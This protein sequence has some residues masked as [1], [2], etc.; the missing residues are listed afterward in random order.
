MPSWTSLQSLIPLPGQVPDFQA[1]LEAF[2]ALGLGKGVQQGP[3][4]LEG[5]VW[6]HTQMVISE[7]S[8]LPAYQEMPRERRVIVFLAALLHDVAKHSTSV[9]DPDTGVVSQPG[10]SRRGSIDARLALWDAGV[11][12]TEREAICRLI[13]NHQ[14]PFFAVKGSRSGQSPEFVV[15]ELSWQLD[16]PLLALL[17]EADVRGRICHDQEAMLEAVELFREQARIEGCFGTRR[18]V[19]DAHT[20]LC[21]FRG[22]EVHP[23]Y[24][25]FQEDGSKVVVM[26]GPPASGKDTWVTQNCP[27][28]PVVSFDDARAELGLRH[29]KNEGMVAHRA[30]D[31]AKDLLR[32]K[33]PFVWNA[34]HLT[35]QTRAR[36]LD[37]L[38]AYNAEVELVYLEQP[39]AELL[40]R[41]HRRDTSL[42]NRALE[43]MLFKWEPP[44][45]YEAHRV[46]Y[47][48][49]EQ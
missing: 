46:R 21:Y 49:T 34:T 10:H 4:H 24:P 44:L 3:H 40:R 37:V 18:E 15:H 1:C 48:P 11:P 35:P 23:D 38:Y 7:L 22:A 29:G 43:E 31:K 16:I 33:K 26:A 42:S 25:L 32:E 28:L 45:P 17:A 39:R 27:G 13:A 9:V 5:D 20:A 2:P 47:V 41:N 8:A 30:F 14:K 12:F 19:V 6:T 36:T